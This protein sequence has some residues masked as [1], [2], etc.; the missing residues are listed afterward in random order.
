M[1]THASSL[2]GIHAN[3]IQS[4]Y[5]RSASGDL[6]R[7]LLRGTHLIE[8]SHSAVTVVSTCVSEISLTR[9]SWQWP[10]YIAAS[11]HPGKQRTLWQCGHAAYLCQVPVH[12]ACASDCNQHVYPNSNGSATHDVRSVVQRLR[13]TAVISQETEQGRYEYKMCCA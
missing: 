4:T 3:V 5:G 11:W 7:G 1:H 13:L 2:P 10:S 9:S 12:L 8:D 6:R